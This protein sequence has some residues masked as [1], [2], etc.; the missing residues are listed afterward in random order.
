MDLMRPLS[1]KDMVLVI[2]DYYS[3]YQK[4][5]FLKSTTLAIII[6]KVTE[7]FQGWE[8]RSQLELIMVNNLSAK[9]S[10]NSARIITSN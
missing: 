5:K 4:I 2:I 8:F 10:N 9:N 7:H 6:K 3:R 1:N